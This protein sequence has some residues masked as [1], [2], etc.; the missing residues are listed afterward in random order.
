MRVIDPKTG[1]S[2]LSTE[3]IAVKA[4]G[5]QLLFSLTALATGRTQLQVVQVFCKDLVHD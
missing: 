1:T 5:V 4:K 3:L 2:K